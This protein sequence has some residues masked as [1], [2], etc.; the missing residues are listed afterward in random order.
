MDKDKGYWLLTLECVLAKLRIYR[1]K[2]LYFW[3]ARVWL[4]AAAIT[5]NDSG[6]DV[7]HVP[8]SVLSEDYNVGKS[9]MEATVFFIGSVN[10]DK[11]AVTFFMSMTCHLCNETSFTEAYIRLK[12]FSR[13][14][15]VEG[16]GSVKSMPRKTCSQTQPLFMVNATVE[17]IMNMTDLCT[18]KPRSLHDQKQ[19]NG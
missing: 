4:E 12:A 2:L 16:Y 9:I 5:V 3:V 15:A 10:R 1:S 18:Q 7:L 6:T 17:S 8:Y 19:V 11:Y 13:A 14:K